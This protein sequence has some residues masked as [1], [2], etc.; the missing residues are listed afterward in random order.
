M[1]VA[2]LF[3]SLATLL[4]SEVRSRVSVLHVFKICHL[5]GCACI[6]LFRLSVKY[7]FTVPLQ[8][9]RFLGCCKLFTKWNA[10]NTHVKS[11]FQNWWRSTGSWFLWQPLCPNP[12]LSYRTGSGIPPQ[13][14][15]KGACSL[16][17]TVGM[18]PQQPDWVQ[19]GH[20][21]VTLQIW[22]ISLKILGHIFILLSLL[23]ISREQVVVQKQ[24]SVF[25]QWTFASLYYYT[26]PSTVFFQVCIQFVVCCLRAFHI[27]LQCFPLMNGLVDWV[28]VAALLQ[29]LFHV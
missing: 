20:L 13:L 5:L 29:C 8:Q 16:H 10:Q 15:G 21:V 2:Q 17:V 7:V 14:L 19:A 28:M 1:C 9:I 22:Q 18:Q 26:L 12:L 6:F 11:V 24:G 4:Q 3:S 25:P 23:L 27:C